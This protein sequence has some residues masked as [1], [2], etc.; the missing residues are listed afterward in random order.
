MSKE[1]ETKNMTVKKLRDMTL[2]TPMTFYDDETET[3]LLSLDINYGNVMATNLDEREVV[4]QQIDR[5]KG[6]LQV[7]IKA[8]RIDF[9][10]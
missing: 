4:N 10:K 3:E 7:F 9:I 6:V 1:M 8:E 2:D 5:Y